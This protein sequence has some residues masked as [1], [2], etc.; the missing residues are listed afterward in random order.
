MA[1]PNRGRGTENGLET[2][3]G[4][5]VGGGGG[6]RRE[7]VAQ[8][9]QGDDGLDGRGGA[10]GVAGDGLGGTEVRPGGGQ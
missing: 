10:E 5:D 9:Q 2:E 7:A 6:G 4:I 8:G 3:F 1:A